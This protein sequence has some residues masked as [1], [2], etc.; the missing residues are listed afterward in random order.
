MLK[1]MWTNYRSELSLDRIKSMMTIKFNTDQTCLEFHDSIKNRPDI[2]KAIKSNGKYTSQ[3]SGILV[4]L[5]LTN[6]ETLENNVV[7]DDSDVDDD[8]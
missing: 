8:E 6:D 1:G 3:Q 4:P 2:L 7:Y 5:P